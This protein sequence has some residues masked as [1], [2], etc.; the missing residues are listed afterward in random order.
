MKS[1]QAPA[2][3][4]RASLKDGIAQLRSAHVPS[5]ALATELLLMYV[6][7]RD[8]AFLYAHPEHLLTLAERQHFFA[9]LS[10]RAAG[11]PVQYL[12][13][14]QEFWGLK[15]EVTPA[16][17]IPRPETEHLI[18]VALERIGLRRSNSALKISDVGTG[19]GCIAVA[20]AQELP[21]ARF[22][23]TDISAEALAVA[24]RNAARHGVGDRIRFELGD[25]LAVLD[26][27]EQFDVIVSNPPYV[28][29]SAAD[30]LAREV[31]EH[32]PDA[33][34]FGGPTGVE[35][36][37]RLLEQAARY[38]ISG[39]TLVLELGYDSA[40]RVLGMIE[41]SGVWTS[42]IVTNDLAGI[43]RVLAAGRH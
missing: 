18:E 14:E 23:A 13:G 7:G 42:A 15:F 22:V 4:I 3:D 17:L 19:S 30:T 11:E 31:R 5:A 12:T 32:E 25:L 8:R 43:P 38:L 16:V 2:A 41:T 35:I 21:N 39:G 28:A 20:L 34:L 6:L 36:Y 37:Q 40:H 29:R 27:S 1:I 33:A 24:A 26:P 9:L 10:R